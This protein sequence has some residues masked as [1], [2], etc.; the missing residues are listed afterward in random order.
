MNP[1]YATQDKKEMITMLIITREIGKTDVLAGT[2][3]HW[4][5][6]AGWD[7]SVADKMVPEVRKYKEI[8]IAPDSEEVFDPEKAGKITEFAK[9]L[10]G[11]GAGSV[12]ILRL[13]QKGRRTTICG[14][15]LAEPE[16]RRKEVLMDLL[17]VSIKVDPNGRDMWKAMH[18]CMIMA[19]LEL[20]GARSLDGDEYL[21]VQLSV[22]LSAAAQADAIPRGDILSTLAYVAGLGGSETVRLMAGSIPQSSGG[23]EGLCSR[24]VQERYGPPWDAKLKLN[25]NFFAGLIIKL[26]PII[27]ELAESRFY[28]CDP[29]TALWSQASEEKIKDLVRR[30]FCKIAAEAGQHALIVRCTDA[31]VSSVMKTI[32]GIAGESNIFRTP[33][34]S[35]HLTDRTLLFGGGNVTQVPSIPS[36]MS[37]NMTR[38]KYDASAQCP[39][40]M[41]ELLLPAMDEDDI[42]LVQ[43]YSGIIMMGGNLIQGILTLTGTPGGGKGTFCEVIAAVVGQENIA[44]LRTKH[45]GGRFETSSCLGKTLLMAGDVPSDF[46][47]GNGAYMLKKLVGGDLLGTERKGRNTRILVHGEYPVV[48]TSNIRLRVRLDGDVDAWRR[49]LMVVR[50]DRPPVKMPIPNFSRMLVAEEGPG[51]TNFMVQGAKMAMADIE[52]YGRLL[53]TERQMARRDAILDESRSLEMFV[54]D[55]IVSEVGGDVTTEEIVTEHAKWSRDRQWDIPSPHAVEKQIPDVIIRKFQIMKRHDILRESATHRGFKGIVLRRPQ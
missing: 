17:S 47:Q 49:R 16:E 30:V 12:R 1:L 8:C 14:L 10:Y 5:E 39:R 3:A 50:Y 41:N 40:F 18:R 26:Y 37:R 38:I 4:A 15:I 11:I 55:F 53:L 28:Q 51:I 54:D 48:I 33:K 34:G 27:F 44:E 6:N 21:K 24:E 9:A 36:A 42:V 45:M 20:F 29:D 13:P 46:L 19:I 23:W 35:L 31:F 22:V 52:K 43:K 32:K 25:Q 2:G 7:P